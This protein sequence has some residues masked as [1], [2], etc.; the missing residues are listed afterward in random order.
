MKRLK[1]AV[2]G[3]PI[4]HSRSPQLQ[5][6]FADS[7]GLDDFSYERIE[8]TCE[9]LNDTVN[10]L[11]DEGY[12]GFNC[13]M[14]LKTDMAALADKLTHEAELLRS[15]NTVAVRDGKLDCATTDG[16][17]IILTA[18]RALGESVSG[19]RVLLLG[20]G[21]AARSAALSLKLAG[22]K[23]TILNRTLKSALT[24]NEMLDGSAVCDALTE[25]NL[26]K[27]AADTE[28]LVNCT[29]AGMTGQPEFESLDFLGNMK[30][31]TSVI[32]AVYNPLETKL[33]CRARELGLNAVSG[34]WMLVYQGALAF[35]WWTGIL[36]DE[37]ACEAAFNTIAAD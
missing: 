13:T 2:L 32:D 22:A 28:L 25:D 6:V 3:S 29:A 7:I 36:P 26:N 12:D 19:K 30:M 21:G 4:A 23:L 37:T 27:A 10:R 31:G 15:V 16:G 35:E 33:L 24:L 18:N 20:A 17:G 1:L 5:R 34:L 9:T 14:P 11:V 8:T